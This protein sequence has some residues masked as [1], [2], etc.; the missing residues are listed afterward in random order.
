[1]T[2]Q[3]PRPGLNSVGWAVIIGINITFLVICIRSGTYWPFAV[4]AIA[5][6]VMAVL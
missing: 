1:M 3:E 4:E 5:F 2:T 6:I